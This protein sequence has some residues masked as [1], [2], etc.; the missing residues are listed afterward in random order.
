MSTLTLTLPSGKNISSIEPA[1]RFSTPSS[2]IVQLAIRIPSINGNV[3]IIVALVTFV[4]FIATVKSLCP[5][6]GNLLNRVL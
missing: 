2:R 1:P 4:T 6:F 3:N 5:E